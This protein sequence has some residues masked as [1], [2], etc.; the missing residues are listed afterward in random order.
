[1]TPRLARIAKICTVTAALALVGG[2]CSSSDDTSTTT[3]TSASGGAAATGELACLNLNDLYALVGPESNGFANWTDAQALATELGSDTTFPDAPLDITAPGTESGTYDAFI[4]LAL[5]DTIDA[6]VEAGKVEAD[7]EGKVEESTRKDY[8]SQASDNAILTGLEGSDT[9]FGW[10]GFAFAEE[11]GDA[12]FEIEIDGGDGCIAPDAETI[13]DGTYPLSRDLYIYVDKAQLAENPAVCEYISY[14]VNDGL[15]AVGEAGYVDMSADDIATT[16]EAA[17]AAGADCATGE[18]SGTVR[19]TGSSTVEPISQLAKELLNETNPDVTVDVDG[20]GTGDGFK[21]FCAGDADV[22]GAS[23]P[24][25][26]AE[27][28]A[29]A[30]A[31][32]EYVELKVAYDGITVLTNANNPGLAG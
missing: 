17:V 9:S 5:Q 28:T 32:I 12:L 15:A 6:R 7:E 26:D 31:G 21:A 8:G 10:V 11:A 1:L 3:D 30:D 25:K 2:A 24:I 16:Q 29:C 14:Y 4:E 22:T 20:P 19:V 18:A 13:A 23:R 27:V